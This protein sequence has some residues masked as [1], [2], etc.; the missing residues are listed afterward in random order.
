MRLRCSTPAAQSGRAQRAA[1]RTGEHERSESEP[2]ELHDRAATAS[3]SRPHSSPPPWQGVPPTF[4]LSGVVAVSVDPPT[5]EFRPFDYWERYDDDSSADAAGAV[6]WPSKSKSADDQ[7]PQLSRQQRQSLF[8]PLTR[9]D[10]V[11]LRTE[12]EELRDLQPTGE[13]VSWR[14]A[15]NRWRR[16]IEDRRGQETVFYNPETDET[17]TGSDPH[18]FAPGYSDKQ[19]AKLKDLERG[20]R[21]EYG[22]RLHTAMLS[23]TCSSTTETGK[24]RPPVDHLDELLSSQSAVMRALRR[25]TDHQRSERLVILEPHESGY[26]HLHVA[27]FVDGVITAEQFRPVIEAHLRNCDGASRSAHRV[28][29]SAVSVN[30]VGSDRDNDEIENLGTYLAE[31]LGC[32]GDDPLDAPPKQQMA[33]AMLWATG[34]RRWRPSDGAQSYMAT[35]SSD[36]DSPWEAV[37]IRNAEGDEFEISDDGGGVEKFKTNFDDRPPPG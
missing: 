12:V 31:Y 34:R 17:A 19:Y 37:A 29:G 9:R 25:A 28:D 23:L 6:S 27:V 18:R 24:P 2:S 36:E 15:L 32:Y 3:R 5:D 33:N 14:G 8:Q 4:P 20:L 11:S 1:T 26:V 30:H 10:G 21:E 7:T 13:P 16:Y 22:K 35:E